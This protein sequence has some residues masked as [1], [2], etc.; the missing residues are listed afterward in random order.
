MKRALI[1][2]TVIILGIVGVAAIGG[3]FSGENEHSDSGAITETVPTVTK[4]SA[5]QAKE[6]MDS[7]EPYILLDVRTDAEYA[8]AHIPGAK[9]LT[10]TEI[11]ERAEAELPNKDATIIVYCRS[12]GRSAAA[13]QELLNMGYTKIYDMGGILSWPYETA[14]GEQ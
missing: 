11:A 4:I 8:E 9:L 13:A 12:G 6:M 10:N 5:E 7:D 3:A 1:A 14:N 2:V